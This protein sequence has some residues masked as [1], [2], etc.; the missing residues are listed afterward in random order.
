M[1]SASVRRPGSGPNLQIT[2]NGLLKASSTRE[3]AEE[4]LD[5]I[6]W[7]RCRRNGGGRRT[8]ARPAGPSQAFPGW[9]KPLANVGVEADAVH[10]VVEGLAQAGA[11]EVV[12]R[13]NG[14]VE[15]NVVVGKGDA[16]RRLQGDPILL[17]MQSDRGVGGGGEAV[18]VR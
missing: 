8:T 7:Y 9:I 10:V 18:P 2:S 11:Q 16:F 17:R 13:A 5:Q 14:V 12:I 3:S 15:R 4:V 6:G 1:Y